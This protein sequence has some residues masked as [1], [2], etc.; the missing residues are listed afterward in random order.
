MSLFAVVYLPGWIL[1]RF[2]HRGP[3]RQNELIDVVPL[4]WSDLDDKDNW[5]GRFVESMK[6][7]IDTLHQSFKGRVDA[8][9]GWPTYPVE[10]IGCA[11]KYSCIITM[12]LNMDWIVLEFIDTHMILI[13]ST[14]WF[15]TRF[16][17]I[18]SHATIML[19]LA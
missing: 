14:S 19:E 9:L 5:I 6:E 1:I 15:I 11:S 8:P 10:I 12:S 3:K 16:N 17:F 18:Y 7:D 13:S 4:G 2:K